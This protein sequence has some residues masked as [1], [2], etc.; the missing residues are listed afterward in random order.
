MK[1]L[2]QETSKDNPNIDVA[3]GL[4]SWDHTTEVF[5]V[6]DV[7]ARGHVV[8]GWEITWPHVKQFMEIGIKNGLTL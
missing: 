2:H 6:L 4:A 3:Y 7:D 8:R 1:I 5:K